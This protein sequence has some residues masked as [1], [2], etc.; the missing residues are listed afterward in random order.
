MK[1]RSFSVKKASELRGALSQCEIKKPQV[2]MV[3][4]SL[5]WFQNESIL[6]EVQSGFPQAVVAGCS[7]AGEI[8]GTSVDEGTLALLALEFESEGVRTYP[9]GFPQ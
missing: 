9:A 5:D 2:V 4:G 7:T 1:A 6:S 8:S 3:F